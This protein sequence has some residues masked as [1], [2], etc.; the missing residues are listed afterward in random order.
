MNKFLH[1]RFKKIHAKIAKQL[2]IKLPL[3]LEKDN[4][5]QPNQ[6][7]WNNFFSSSTKSASIFSSENTLTRVY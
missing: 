6:S 5:N 7:W 3:V 4:K 1:V 2:T